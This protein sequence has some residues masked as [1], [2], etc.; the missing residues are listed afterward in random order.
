MQ[1][2]HQVQHSLSFALGSTG[3]PV[4]GELFVESVLPAPDVGHL[5]VTVSSLEPERDIVE[6]LKHLQ[7]ASG[8]LRSEVAADISRRR[9]PDLTFR[10]LPPDEAPSRQ[11]LPPNREDGNLAG[12]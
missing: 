9:V 4:L 1:F 2:C 8:R 10:C 12:Q 6:I 11:P 3:D 7:T 5:L